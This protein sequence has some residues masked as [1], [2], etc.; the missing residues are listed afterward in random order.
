MLETFVVWLADEL[1]AASSSLVDSSKRVSLWY[2]L[3]AVL[4]AWLV[5][6]LRYGALGWARLKPYLSWRVWWHRSARTD[7]QLWL[8][9]RL[10]LGVLIPKTFT[11]AVW[12]SWLYFY[13]QQQG[14]G[15]LQL[16]WSDATVVVL[17]SLCYFLVDDFSRFLVHW[18]MHKTPW[19]WA[20]H[21][22]HHGAKVLTPFTVFRTH[23]IEGLLFFLRSMASQSLVISI[24]LV[25]F[26]NQVS[27]WQVFGV[28]ITTFV[29]NV[30]GA[31][32]RHSGVALSYGSKLEKWLISPAQHQVHH[33]VARQH[34]DRNFGVTLA[35]WDRLFGSWHPGNDDQTLRYGTGQAIDEMG[36]LGQWLEPFRSLFQTLQRRT[37]QRL[38]LRLRGK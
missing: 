16:G 19:L 26:P 6:S 21:Q 29:F 8:A 24:F 22:V 1:A 28:L 7:Y 37:K 2:L 10:L 23:P 15:D 32:L 3:S 25:A 5:L 36:M 20:F 35:L 13:W 33:S 11:Q 30:L 34:Y 14:F 31:N 17:F 9:N 38:K 27:L 12:V 18:A 4:F